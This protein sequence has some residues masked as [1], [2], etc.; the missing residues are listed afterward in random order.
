M[1]LFYLLKVIRVFEAPK[2]F[3]DMFAVIS[4]I[5]DENV[6]IEIIPRY[7]HQTAENIEM[8]KNVHAC[9]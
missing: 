5:S 1:L 9:I 4:Q 7:Y 8:F 6:R 2:S 3:V